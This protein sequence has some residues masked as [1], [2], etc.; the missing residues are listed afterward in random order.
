MP[1]F[2]GPFEILERFGPI[3][4]RIALPP[5]LSHIHDIFHV[6]I[7]RQYILDVTHVLDLDALQLVDGKLSLDL[8][9]IL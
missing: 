8:I 7:L 6:S 2:F 5:S 1:C 4:Y 9:H 3:S